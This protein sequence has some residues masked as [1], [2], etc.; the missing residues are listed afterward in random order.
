MISPQIIVPEHV[1]QLDASMRGSVYSD[2]GISCTS[3]SRHPKP[4]RGEDELRHINKMYDA[5]ET[6]SVRS[7]NT[8]RSNSTYRSAGD[9]S[10]EHI[11]LTILYVEF[12]IMTELQIAATVLKLY[13]HS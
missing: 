6:A 10:G 1:K 4:P 7:H 3:S 2:S 5:H 8:S 13:F 9:I 12:V 11:I